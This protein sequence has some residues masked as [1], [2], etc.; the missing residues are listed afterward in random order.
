MLLECSMC[1]CRVTHLRHHLRSVHGILNIQEHQILLKL[2]RGRVKL[3]NLSCPVCSREF[4]YI[5]KHLDRGHPDLTV[6]ITKAGSWILIVVGWISSNIPLMV[7]LWQTVPC[8]FSFSFRLQRSLDTSETSCG[9]WRRRNWWVWGQQ[10][11]RFRWWALLTSPQTWWRQKRPLP[12]NNNNFSLKRT[13]FKR[14]V[15]DVRVQYYWC[16]VTVF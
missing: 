6:S 10:T 15:S 8:C 7:M 16:N 3:R 4:A 9:R 12:N 2:A 5:E 1:F 14:W 13:F 11:P